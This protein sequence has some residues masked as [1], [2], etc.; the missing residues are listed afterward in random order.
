MT[1]LKQLDAAQPSGLAVFITLSQLRER[2]PL[3]ERTIR[4]QIKKGLLPVIILPGSRR[5]LFDWETVRSTLL[6]HQRGEGA[7]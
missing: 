5:L 4:G 1:E 6:R 2:L 7:V 3:S